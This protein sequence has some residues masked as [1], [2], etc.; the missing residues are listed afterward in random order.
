MAPRRETPS[1]GSCKSGV[2][3][4][5]GGRI[6]ETRFL[7]CTMMEIQSYAPDHK[8]AFWYVVVSKRE[9]VLTTARFHTGNLLIEAVV[10]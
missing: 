4:A 1:G 5:G 3:S 6:Y 7:A 10:A 9:P 2:D 8:L